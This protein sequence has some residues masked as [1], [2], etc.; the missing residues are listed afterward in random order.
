MNRLKSLYLIGCYPYAM[1]DTLK[2]ISPI[3][4]VAKAIVLFAQTPD[5]CVLFY[6]NNF[7]RVSL[8]NF[9]ARAASAG[10]GIRAVETE[11]YIAALDEA[12]SDPE[13]LGA[14]VGL[15][16]YEGIYKGMHAVDYS[17][18]YSNQVLLRMGFSWPIISSDYINK[19]IDCLMGIGF[20]M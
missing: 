10:L 17:N 20:F 4:D 11:E 18:A 19:M 9:Y 2:D 6:G 12:K 16:A 13:K 14:L 15:M 7:N 5:K 1:Y 3:D 8:G